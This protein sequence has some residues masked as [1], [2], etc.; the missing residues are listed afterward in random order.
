ME[1]KQKIL[2][3]NCFSIAMKDIHKIYSLYQSQKVTFFAQKAVSG[4]EYETAKK[5][6]IF[7]QFTSVG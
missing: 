3:L 2:T 7:N 5:A 4:N 6:V 1:E